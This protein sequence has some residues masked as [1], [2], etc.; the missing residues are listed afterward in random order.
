M[1]G[2]GFVYFGAYS[3]A[4][5]GSQKSLF[6]KK[7][8]IKLLLNP[9]ICR[10]SLGGKTGGTRYV[11]K[12]WQNWDCYFW[13][14]EG[15]RGGAAAFIFPDNPVVKSQRARL[16][17]WGWKCVHLTVNCNVQPPGFPDN[18]KSTAK[19]VLNVHHCVVKPSLCNSCTVTVTSSRL[20][21][22]STL[23]KWGIFGSVRCCNALG[24]AYSDMSLLEYAYMRDRCVSLGCLEAAGSSFLT[25]L[26]Q[27]GSST[28]LKPRVTRIKND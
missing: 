23:S 25:V 4:L 3:T 10:M 13:L 22:V 24:D 8:K 14:T 28:L 27:A 6:W 19:K 11:S 15:L 20:K 1:E 16:C 21:P 17:S 7:L 18:N 9:G 26:V 2:V 12:V 5:L